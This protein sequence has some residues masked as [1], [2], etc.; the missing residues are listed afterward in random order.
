MAKVK[1]KGTLLKLD[2]AATLTDVAQLLSLKPPAF[3]STDYGEFTLDQSG[4]GRERELTGYAE[5]DPFEAEFYWD[6]D[7]AVHDAIIDHITAD[8]PTEQTWQIL[9]VNTGA[10]TIDWTGVG[11]E[12]S[13]TVPVGDGLKASIKGEVDGLAT[14]T[15]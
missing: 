4:T 6:P 3:R 7:L 12:M 13:P 5:S 8:P 9:F 15:Q 11:L 10:S 1:S 14:Y 2:I